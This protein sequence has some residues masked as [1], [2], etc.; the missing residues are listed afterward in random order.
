VWRGGTNGELE[1]LASC[2][3]RSIELAAAKGSISVAFPSV[4][5]GIY[6]Y[7]VALAAMVA[8]STVTQSAS[9]FPAI[10]EIVFCCF[11]AE[12]LAVYES[13]LNQPAA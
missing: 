8:V 6:G 1:L 5:T 12:D 3:R 4:S 11:S 7:P 2:Y 10:Q 9:T 13:A